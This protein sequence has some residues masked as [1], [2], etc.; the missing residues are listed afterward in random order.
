M[1]VWK[2]HLLQMRNILW[3]L[4]LINVISFFVLRSLKVMGLTQKLNVSFWI[5]IDLQN[6]LLNVF[7]FWS[8][9]WHSD[10]FMFDQISLSLIFVLYSKGVW[11]SGGWSV[12]SCTIW[13][14]FWNNDS[15]LSRW[16]VNNLNLLLV[17]VFLKMLINDW[18]YRIWF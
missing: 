14:M 1:L 3:D 7:V 16:S 17:D 6:L 9:T 8:K 11:I 5:S 4:V 10:Y 18:F 12:S 13:I 2:F 15:L